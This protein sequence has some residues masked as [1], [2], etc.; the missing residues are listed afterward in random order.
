MWG[1][2]QSLGSATTSRDRLGPQQLEGGYTGNHFLRP[3]LALV[4]WLSEE[5]LQ[6]RSVSKSMPAPAATSPGQERKG[7]GSGVGFSMLET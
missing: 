3:G 1:L 7:K 2:R 4:F 5:K 6:L